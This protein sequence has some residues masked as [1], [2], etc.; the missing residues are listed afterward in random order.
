[1][2]RERWMLERE[3]R[4]HHALFEKWESTPELL[5]EE[6]KAQGR[7]D[8]EKGPQL[9]EKINELLAWCDKKKQDAKEQGDVALYRAREAGRA[10]SQGDGF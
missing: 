2:E 6:E 7:P 10:W 9:Q 4:G 5:T 3:E 8:V 1:M